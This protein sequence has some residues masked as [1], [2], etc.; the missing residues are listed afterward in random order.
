VYSTP[1]LVVIGFYLL[2]YLLLFLFRKRFSP[3]ARTF[4]RWAVAIF[5]VLNELAWHL[6]NIR[7]GTWSVRDML[8]LHICSV[9]VFA[10][11]I[12][13]VTKSYRV[14]EFQYFLGIA[15]ASQVLFTPDAGVYNFP[16]FRF[17]QTFLSHGMI[18]FTAL[19]MTFV[20]G[21]RPTAWSLLKVAVG[22]NGYILI[23]GL[24]NIPL[25]SNYLFLMQK[26]PIPSLLD[27][28]GPWP[29][30]IL[31]MEVIGAAICVL[32]YLPFPLAELLEKHLPNEV[33]NT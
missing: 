25:E 23:V 8:P 17:F 9:M 31:G 4:L 14:Y 5:L 28:L 22:M 15:A 1:Q 27:Y 2:L 29:W 10:S 13:L 20:E 16:D 11:A 32:L 24:V 7:A 21:F 19:Y 18:I 6:Y 30:Y 33:R 26:A 12:L 3:R